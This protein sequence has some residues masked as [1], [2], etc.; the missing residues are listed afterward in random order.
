MIKCTA[1]LKWNIGAKD[2]IFYR[3]P[4]RILY[5]IARQTL[6]MSFNTIPKKT[7]EMRTQSMSRGVYFTSNLSCAI[8]SN[9]SYASRVWS[10]NADTTRWT[11]PG[12]TSQWY[13]KYWQKHGKRII[14]NVIDRNRNEW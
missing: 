4:R 10:L 7:G 12:T 3:K 8:S 5:E 9:T 11:T 2:K 14:Q 13:L 1:N 6:D